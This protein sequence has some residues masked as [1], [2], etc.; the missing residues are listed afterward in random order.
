MHK[1]VLATSTAAFLLIGGAG[2]LAYWQT[3]DTVGAGNV[4]SGRLALA[5]GDPGA[6]RLNGTPV[7]DPTAVRVVPGDQLTWAGSFEIDA[8][9]DNL[10]GTVGVTGGGSSGGL[11][12]YVGTTAVD[13]TV[14]GATHD[15]T[16][17]AADD[18]KTLAVDV[19]VDFPFGSGVD[20]A[21][22]DKVIDLSDV[23]VTITQTDA[24]PS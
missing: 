21:S 8:V 1:A 9:G 17:T 14:D 4:S 2:S 23:T 3:S 13:W 6:W 20:N 24:T 11:A 19:A 10:Q 12:A 7:A 16:I 5:G 18:G 22:Q 15:P